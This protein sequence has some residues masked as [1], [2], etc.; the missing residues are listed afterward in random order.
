M[1]RVFP[2]FFFCCCI[3]FLSGC[4]GQSAYQKKIDET[5]ALTRDLAEVRKRNTDLSRENAQL[6]VKIDGLG[7][8]VGELEAGKKALEDLLAKRQDTPSLTIAEQ[9]QEIERLRGDL[10]SLYRER[11]EKVRDISSLYENLLSRMKDEV[12]HGR[13]VVSEL[14]GTV[15]ISVPEEVFFDAGSN[16]VTPVGISML[17]T[18]AELAAG[19][20]SPEVRVEI[21]FVISGERTAT[22][23]GRPSWELAAARS[24]AV[25]DTFR[26]HGVEPAA[27][28]AGISGVFGIE[29]ES[30]SA[31][32]PVKAGRVG[33]MLVLKE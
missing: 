20:R 1:V 8:T 2:V 21:P 12:A 9:G 10:A 15:T 13:A 5:S 33:I 22:G 23:S 31:P 27:I 29:R 4:V 3:V 25:A 28:S 16:T 14:R 6:Q 19:V 26:V 30:G 11:E 24:V 18:I 17:R 32:L 7:R